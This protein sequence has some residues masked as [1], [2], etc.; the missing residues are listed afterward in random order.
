MSLRYGSRTTP[1]LRYLCIYTLPAP[2]PAGLVVDDGVHEGEYG[3]LQVSGV[4]VFVQTATQVHNDRLQQ[5]GEF[6]VTCVALDRQTFM[7]L[8]KVAA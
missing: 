2:Y 3:N 4:L 1:A 7:Q 6:P 5:K 8:Y